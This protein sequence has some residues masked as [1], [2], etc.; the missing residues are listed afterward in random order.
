MPRYFFFVKPP[1][2]PVGG[3]KTNYPLSPIRSL[4]PSPSPV[5]RGVNS[6][7]THER[8]LNVGM[9]HKLNVGTHHNLNVGTHAMR[10]QADKC[11]YFLTLTY[12]PCG[13]IACVP[14]FWVRSIS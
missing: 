1:C 12:F 6:L 13:R 7:K 8:I 14:T 11:P 3:S 9:H 5:G 2:P 10:P 4:S